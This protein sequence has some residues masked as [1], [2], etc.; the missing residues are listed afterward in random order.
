MKKRHIITIL[1]FAAMMALQFFFLLLPQIKES[2]KND[3]LI[4]ESNAKIEQY[5]KTMAEFPGFFKT[6][7]ELFKKKNSLISRLYS[8]NDLIKLFD[9]IEKLSN[10]HEL[11]VIEISPSVEE[12]LKLNNR[13]LDSDRPQPLN[14]VV[15]FKGDLQNSGKY[16]E[17]IESEDFFNGVNLCRIYNHIDNQK[18]SEINFGFKAILGTIKDS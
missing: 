17:A 6:Q 2:E 8:R 12:L 11:T 15:R 10:G 1:A 14:I 7:Q 13:L 9:R 3:R 4:S 16:I 5:M 18:E